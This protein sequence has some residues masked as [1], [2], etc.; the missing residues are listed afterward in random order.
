IQVEEGGQVLLHR[1]ATDAEEDR[2]RKAEVRA[3]AR[4]EQFGIDAARPE[5]DIAK[6]ALVHLAAKRRGRD[7]HAVAGIVETAQPGVAP[8]L[9]YGQARAEKFGKARMI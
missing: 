4:M 6:A 5:P 7:Q 2:A 1:D 3:P 8:A 9:R